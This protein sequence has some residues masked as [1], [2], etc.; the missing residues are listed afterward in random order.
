MTSTCGCGYTIASLQEFMY[1]STSLQWQRSWFYLLHFRGLT[2][3]IFLVLQN[4]SSLD[5]VTP[6]PG[7]F[8]TKLPFVSL[9][10]NKDEETKGKEVEGE[11]ERLIGNKEGIEITSRFHKQFLEVKKKKDKRKLRHEKWLQSEYNISTMS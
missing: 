11:V 1:L 4:I 8:L 10:S 5:S 7:E 3:P 9:H 6:I 2:D